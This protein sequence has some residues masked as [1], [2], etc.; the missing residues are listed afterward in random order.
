[1]LKIDEL[2]K[3]PKILAVDTEIYTKGRS[4]ADPFLDDVTLLSMADGT[5][6]FVLTRDFIRAKQ[7]LEDSSITKLCHNYSFDYKYLK[8]LGIAPVNFWDTLIVERVIQA[9]RNV[10]NALDAVAKRRLGRSLNKSIRTSFRKS[11][12]DR[13]KIEYAGDDADVLVGIY[14]DQRKDIENLGL[15]KVIELENQVVPIT[16]E[17]E[18]HGIGF[19]PVAWE[20][21]KKI[22]EAQKYELYLKIIKALGVSSFTLSLFGD[23]VT[24][25][26]NL[27]SQ[28]EVIKEFAKNGIYLESTDKEAIKGYLEDNP[29]CQVLRDF[30]EYRIHEKALGFDYPKWVHP[31]TGRIHCSFNQI[32]TDTAR[33]SSNDPNMQQVKRSKEW[34][35]LFTAS[36]GKRLVTADYSQLQLRLM[37]E[38]SEC[39]RMTDA[40]NKGIDLHSETASKAFGEK[41]SKGDSRR[42]LGKNTNFAK[43]FGAYPKTLAASLGV[44][45][46]VAKNL[47]V[48]FEKLYPEVEDWGNAQFDFVSKHGYSLDVLNRRRWFPDITAETMMRYR[49]ISRNSPIQ[50]YEADV[51]KTAMLGLVNNGYRPVLQVHD[52]IVVEVDKNDYS[53]EVDIP[54]IMKE[55]GETLMT[56][57]PLEVDASISERWSK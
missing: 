54:K 37:A 15:I 53:A 13:E 56:K 42:Q 24:S 36:P 19:D 35:A 45:L 52:E 51:V 32:G 23:E 2:P 44:D 7:L 28:K 3:N 43:I 50:M 12:I 34:R 5:D 26:L 14:K 6:I 46:S 22:E 39:Q 41:I 11:G 48:A 40:F 25:G 9:G 38:V 31:K 17:M 8:K 20:A 1:M 57:V 29:T 33:Y 55:S 18:L 27:N 21:L 49:N 30:Q 4:Y 16:A 47:S 10:S